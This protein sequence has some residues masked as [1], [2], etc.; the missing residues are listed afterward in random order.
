MDINK[1]YNNVLLEP[2]NGQVYNNDEPNARDNE[3]SS[4]DTQMYKYNPSEVIKSL[5]SLADKTDD[6]GKQ[7]YQPAFTYTDTIKD[8]FSP[9]FIVL[10]FDYTTIFL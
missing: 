9:L 10:I 2:G 6:K 7:L 8:I 5:I 4:A 1:E 3:N